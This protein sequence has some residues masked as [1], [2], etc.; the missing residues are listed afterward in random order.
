MARPDPTSIR[1]L[2]VR[3]AFQ[4]TCRVRRDNEELRA[5]LNA[6]RRRLARRD[7]LKRTPRL[8]LLA[9]PD[10]AA[11]L[12]DASAALALAARVDAKRARRKRRAAENE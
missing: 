11:M 8:T 10:M 5:R 4:M 3:V 6:A 1:R 2:I 9:G 12:N 7:K